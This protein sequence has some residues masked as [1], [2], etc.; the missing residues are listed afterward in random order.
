MGKRTGGKMTVRIHLHICHGTE[1]M[2]AVMTTP[3]A[4]AVP[5]ASC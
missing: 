1:R 4:C 5:T 3:A 2:Y